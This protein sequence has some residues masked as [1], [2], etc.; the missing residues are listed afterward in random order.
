MTPPWNPATRPP[1]KH[2]LVMVSLEDGDVMKG[3][4]DG[5][6]WCDPHGIRLTDVVA[7]RNVQRATA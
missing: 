3:Y 7:W 2:E 6:G 5:Y 4:F 1:R